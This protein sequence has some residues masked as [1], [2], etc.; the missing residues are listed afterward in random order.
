MT[1][2]LS[3]KATRELFPGFWTQNKFFLDW[4]KDFRIVEHPAGFFEGI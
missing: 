4:K 2:S 3:P 1:K